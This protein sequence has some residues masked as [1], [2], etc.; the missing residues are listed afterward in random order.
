MKTRRKTAKPGPKKVARGPRL[1]ARRIL[2]APEGGEVTELVHERLVHSET[3]PRLTGG[4][5]D[6]DWARAFDSG[7]EAVGG[8][9]MT[10]DQDV[11]DEIGRALGVEQEPDAEV[12]TCDE[13]LRGRDQHYW[14]LER[15]AEAKAEEAEAGEEE[16]ETAREPD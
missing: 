7:E 10:P 12:E 11:V 6:A 14:A 13:I 9:V 16:G 4:D 8:S 1:R 5:L 15:R 2:E 3:G